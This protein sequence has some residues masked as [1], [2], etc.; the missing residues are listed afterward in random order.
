MSATCPACQAPV[1]E[2]A[3]FCRTCGAVINP[4]RAPAPPSPALDIAQACD[5]C[6]TVLIAQAAFCHSCGSAAPSPEPEIPER[7]PCPGC[8]AEIDGVDAFCRYCGASTKGIAS[9]TPAPPT[10]ER[11]T[12]DATHR[13]PALSVEQAHDSDAPV[14]APSLAPEPADIEPI[15]LT[16]EADAS[17]HEPGNAANN[18]ASVL[19]AEPAEDTAASREG[20]AAAEPTPTVREPELERT[21]PAEEPEHS[22]EAHPSPTDG[23]RAEPAV[24]GSSAGPVTGNGTAP[25]VRDQAEGPTQLMRFVA[26]DSP[27]PNHPPGE[28]ITSDADELGTPGESHSET[29]RS[30]SSC[31]AP[32][33]ET[34]RFC[35][36]CGASVAHSDAGVPPPG[37]PT[38][39]CS[40]CGEQIS[41]GA[42][43]CRHC[44][45]RAPAS[46]TTKPISAETGCTM[47][48]APTSAAESLCAHCATAV[49]S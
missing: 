43:F 24:V 1:S 44:G 11:D 49:E 34:A 7:I 33:S 20:E 10:P 15:A 46:Q 19:A 32:I 9:V 28:E 41:P 35:R 47:C 16:D 39:Q 4:E 29:A 31:H 23:H 12:H 3:K 45:A 2:T 26:P 8:E 14:S 27:R 36:S 6:G 22:P 38:A 42:E 18:Q 17:E 48:G 5:T 37:G 21:L 30:C 13:P 40:R 25:P